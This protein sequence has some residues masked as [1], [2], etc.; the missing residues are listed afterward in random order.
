MTQ[1]LP[2]EPPDA[3]QARRDTSQLVEAVGDSADVW[4]VNNLIWKVPSEHVLLIVCSASEL[5]TS[6]N[7][8]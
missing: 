2:E 5:D 7:N 8:G 6:W 4:H 3:S 1:M